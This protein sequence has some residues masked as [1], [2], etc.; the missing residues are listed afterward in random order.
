[1]RFELIPILKCK[2]YDALPDYSNPMLKAAKRGFN[3]AGSNEELGLGKSGLAEHFV[4]RK[5]VSMKTIH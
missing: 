5:S 1:M 4:S 3:F 2:K